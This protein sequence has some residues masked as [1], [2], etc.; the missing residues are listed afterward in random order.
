M[1]WHT[2]HLVLLIGA[3]EALYGHLGDV[4]TPEIRVQKRGEIK[5][6]VSCNAK[7]SIELNKVFCGLQCNEV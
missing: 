6:L 2:G 1:P 4:F 3:L 5:L 7:I